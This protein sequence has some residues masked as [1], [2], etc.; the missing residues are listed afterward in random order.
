MKTFFKTAF[1]IWTL[2]IFEQGGKRTKGIL[3]STTGALIKRTKTT[4]MSTKSNLVHSFPLWTSLIFLFYFPCAQ[5][6]PNLKLGWSLPLTTRGIQLLNFPQNCDIVHLNA[7]TKHFALLCPLQVQL[8]RLWQGFLIA[9][10]GRRQ[11]LLPSSADFVSW[12]WKTIIAATSC[13]TN[14]C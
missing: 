13:H 4:M 3:A 9:Q 10:I 2:F 14:G 11:R 12:P 6:A 8:H 7:D 1:H 5:C